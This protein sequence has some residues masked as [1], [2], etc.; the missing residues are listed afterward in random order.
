MLNLSSL[1]ALT[2]AAITEYSLVND[3]VAKVIVNCSKARPDQLIARLHELLGG[4]ATPIRASFRWLVRDESMIGFVATNHETRVVDK[5]QLTAGFRLVANSSNIYLNKEDD[6][7]WELRNGTGGTYLSKTSSDDLGELIESVRA[8]R[9]GAPR[10]ASIQAAAVAAHEVVAFVYTEDNASPDMEYGFC[11]G[12][13]GEDYLV[14]TANQENPVRV[15]ANTVVGC[16]GVDQEA[17]KAKVHAAT[18][19]GIRAGFDKKPVI[20][21]YKKAYYYDKNYLALVIK[22]IEESAAL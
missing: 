12:R 1:K 5:A 17:L 2:P 13:Q 8:S 9:T 16:Y 19:A 15:S 20:E 10:M 22:Q 11:V 4:K 21:Y 7:I 18:K 3:R 14:V 6:S